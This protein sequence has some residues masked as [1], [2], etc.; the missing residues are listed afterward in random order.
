MKVLVFGAGGL[1]GRELMAQA[2][3]AGHEAHGTIR[4]SQTAGALPGRRGAD[5]L[6]GGHYHPLDLND[7]EAVLALLDQLGPQSI[8]YAAGYHPVDACEAN[9]AGAIKMHAV[10][11]AAIARWCQKHGAWMGY[12]STD[13]VF[14]GEKKGAYVESDTPA[15]QSIYARTKYSGE[16]VLQAQS[17]NIA[18]LRTSVVYGFHPA[19]K[20]FVLW[21]LDELRAGRKV[22]IVDDQLSTPT[23]AGDLAAAMLKLAEKKEGGLFHA[24]GPTCLSRYDFA[25]RIAKVFGLDAKLISP[26]KTSDLK[27]QAARPANGC[28][29]S[30]PLEK[31][32]GLHF[33]SVEKGLQALKLKMGP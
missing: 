6:T 12:V 3:Q 23:Y 28:L 5:P 1:L 11:P 30:K 31:T 21:L 10:L 19:K 18:I 9:P 25:L 26:A 2:M 29:I 24:A 4:Q 33:F 22:K 17:K 7:D 15:P 32:T 27:Q 13:Y 8:F 20:N 16:K 14:D